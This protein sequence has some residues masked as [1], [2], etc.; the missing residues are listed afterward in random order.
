MKKTVL[1]AALAAFVAMPAYAN[2][3]DDKADYY[4]NK[5]DANTDGKIS[6]DEHE[7]FSEAMFKNADTNNDGSLTKDELAAAKKQ[8]KAEMKDAR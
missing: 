6:E 1:M 8:K 5:M 3:M 4:F 2:D 7:N